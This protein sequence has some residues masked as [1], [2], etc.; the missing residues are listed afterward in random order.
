M[1]TGRRLVYNVD[2][3][4]P[5]IPVMPS[6]LEDVP[7]WLRYNASRLSFRVLFLA[8]M[9]AEHLE[10]RAALEAVARETGIRIVDLPTGLTGAEREQF[11]RDTLGPDLEA[12]QEPA[13]APLAA[14]TGRLMAEVLNTALPPAPT[15]CPHC[16][17]RFRTPAELATHVRDTG[18]TT[19]RTRP[20][21]AC[22]V[23]WR[24]RGGQ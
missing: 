16:G 8:D 3:T 23:L 14:R 1:D 18:D 19:G 21:H 15:R 5:R 12:P 7:A 13:T 2:M 6:R 22:P 24:W 20:G 10:H 4:Q 17:D 9:L 11:I